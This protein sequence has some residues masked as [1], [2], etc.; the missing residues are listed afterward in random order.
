MLETDLTMGELAAADEVFLTST[1][2]DVQGL[3]DLDGRLFDAQQPV[4]AQVRQQWANME[5][6]DLDP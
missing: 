5:P 1:T 3:H 6:K 4:T 2:R